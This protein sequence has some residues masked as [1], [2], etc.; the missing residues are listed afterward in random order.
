MDTDTVETMIYNAFGG[1]DNILIGNMIGTDVTRVI[2]NLAAATG[3]A[4]G[5]ADTVTVNATGLGDNITVTMNASGAILVNGLFTVVEIRNFDAR[6]RLIINTGTR[7]RRD[8]CHGA[9]SGHRLPGECRRRQRHAD[10][11]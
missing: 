11:P 1:T 10:R 2:V 8:Q 5:L 4:D 9:R 3:G 7:R 6:D